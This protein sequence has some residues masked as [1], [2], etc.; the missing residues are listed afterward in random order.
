MKKNIKNLERA[1]KIKLENK[2]L[3]LRN[4]KLLC[5]KK[6]QIPYN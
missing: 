1:K 5:Y 3:Q 2:L 6:K 4:Y